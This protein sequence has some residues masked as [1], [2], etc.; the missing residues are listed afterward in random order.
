[1]VTANLLTLELDEEFLLARFWIQ[2]CFSKLDGHVLRIQQYLL[3]QRALYKLEFQH[4]L[5]RLVLIIDLDAD[6]GIPFHQ[7]NEV[8]KPIN[9]FTFKP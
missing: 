4:F 3:L 6:F 2:S 9:F 1:M 7:I 8:H 5:W